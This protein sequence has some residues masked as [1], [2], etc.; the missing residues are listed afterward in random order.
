MIMTT[1]IEMVAKS[2]RDFPDD[3]RYLTD[4]AFSALAIGLPEGL[5]VTVVAAGEKIEDGKHLQH[6][7]I[8]ASTDDGEFC[9]YGFLK[10][11]EPGWA[12]IDAL[13]DL[14]YAQFMESREQQKAEQAQADA[15]WL[16][17]LE[18]YLQSGAHEDSSAER[19]AR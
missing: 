10:Y 16:A 8:S 15:V 18:G 3:W 4:G 17:K 12:E 5:T 1:L 11:G 6:Y 13:Y 7:E 2:V 19:S 9:H 14:R